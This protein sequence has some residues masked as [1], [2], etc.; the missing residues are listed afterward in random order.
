MA[1]KPASIRCGRCWKRNPSGTAADTLS[2]KGKPV[3]KTLVLP[4]PWGKRPLTKCAL[5]THIGPLPQ[6]GRLK[7]GRSTAR[8]AGTNVCFLFH[9]IILSGDVLSSAM[10]RQHKHKRLPRTVIAGA[11]ALTP[12]ANTQEKA[13]LC[14]R[15]RHSRKKE[16]QFSKIA[17][18]RAKRTLK[19]KSLLSQN[20]TMTGGFV[21]ARSYAEVKVLEKEIF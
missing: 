6:G 17:P 18:H 5:H 9:A 14:P 21:M 19:Q 7:N 3:R 15:K 2:R 11:F 4:R 10:K 20:R 12:C 8:P 16:P 13:S 1:K